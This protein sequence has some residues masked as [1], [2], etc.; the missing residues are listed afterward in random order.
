[1][2]TGVQYIGL[3]GGCIICSG[4]IPQIYK[5]IKTK[6]T[7]DLSYAMLIL[8][9]IGLTMA[10][11]YAFSIHQIPIM[12]TNTLS[13][14]MSTLMLLIKIY[15]EKIVKLNIVIYKELDEFK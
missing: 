15:Y 5:M 3:V 12:I 14:C 6:E 9:I 7:A 11:I 10:V 8:W 13:L 2:L 4:A 1:M